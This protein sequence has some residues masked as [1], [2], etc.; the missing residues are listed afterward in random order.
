MAPFKNGH[1]TLLC[2][3]RFLSLGTIDI[4]ELDDYLLWGCPVHR[5]ICNSIPGLYLPDASKQP[6]SVMT[7]NVSTLPNVS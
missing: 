1:T 4:F 7:K 3:A 5:R 6:I 2:R